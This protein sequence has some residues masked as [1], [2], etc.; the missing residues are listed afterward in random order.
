MDGNIVSDVWYNPALVNNTI[1]LN[2]AG[3]PNGYN[4][5]SVIQVYV[6]PNQLAPATYIPNGNCGSLGGGQW[7][8]SMSGT[9]N[10][11]FAD[12]SPTPGVCTF[13][14][15]LVFNCCK[16]AELLPMPQPPFVVVEVYHH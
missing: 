2:L 15:Y 12:M 16:S 1:T 4:Q 3:I 8:A 14:P 6:Y 11:T 9:I 10:A 5:N 13:N 7:T